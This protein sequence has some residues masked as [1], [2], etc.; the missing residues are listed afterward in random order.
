[1]KITKTQLRRLIREQMSPR[2]SSAGSRVANQASRIF[3]D[4]FVLDRSDAGSIIVVPHD[5][6]EVDERYE[7][8]IKIWPNGDELDDGSIDTGIA[9]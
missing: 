4:K 2:P 9:A 8:W 1:M 7:Q 6:D 5:P 3:S